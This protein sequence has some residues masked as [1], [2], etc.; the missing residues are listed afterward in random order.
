MT[1]KPLLT[2]LFVMA[3]AS[4]VQAEIYQ[5]IDADGKAHFSGSKPVNPASIES[6]ND[7]DT[8]SAPVAGKSAVSVDIYMTKWCPYC[9]K[10]M[11]F[12]NKNNIPFTAY[13]IEQDADAAARKRKLD[14]RYSGVP[15]AVIN[16][17][18][19][20]GFSEDLYQ[21]ALAKK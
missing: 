17:A 11:A 7:L 12:L 20:R 19:V 1:I 18:A 10:A 9:K 6:R 4:P 2:L 21:E 14:P 13:D 16:G 3:F 15:L 8:K 5:W